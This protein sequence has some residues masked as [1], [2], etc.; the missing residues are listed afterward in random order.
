MDKAL[1][2]YS[3]ADIPAKPKDFICSSCVKSK[4]TRSFRLSTSRKIR[5]NLDLVHSDL[6]GPFP[7]PSY[8]N[9]LY[10]I[11]LVDDA[12][13]VAW[14]RFMKQKSETTK[15]IKDF[16]TEMEHQHHKSPKAFRTDN[17]GEYVTKDLKGFFESKGIIHEFTPPYSPE[18]NGVAERLNQTIEEALRAMLERA[19]TY[20][21]KLWAE[22]VLTAIYIKN[23]Q[24]HSALKDLT[25][26]EAFYGSKPSIQHL[27]PFGREWYIHVPYQKRT[28]GKKLSP[29]AQ[30]AIVTGYTN[31]INHYRVF[32][33]DTKKTIV[34]ADIFFLPLQIVG[35]SPQRMKSIHQHQT[36]SSQTSIDYTYTNK[37]K[38]TDNLWRQWMRENPQEANNMFNNGNPTIDRF[39]LADFRA[40][41]RDEYLGA[42][43][44]VYN[45]NDMAY[46]ETLPEQPVEDDIQSFD[47]SEHTAISDDHFFR[48]R[49]TS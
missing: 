4:M 2:L 44:W 36:P 43:Y 12:T 17:G 13:R 22:A 34:S 30:R 10:Y 23:R 9:S 39:I 29:R 6:S 32:L 37:S 19:V 7:V 5:N 28:D 49:R 21:K 38:G 15:I 33:P 35:G 40:G 42:P 47:G 20:D 1:K 27:Q 3:D 48:R 41:K 26:Y 14:V 31:T 16:V 24:P 45:D 46:R 18:S 8:G 11:T 25:P